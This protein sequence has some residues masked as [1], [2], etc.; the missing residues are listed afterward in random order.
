MDN[1]TA[2]NLTH[3]VRPAV[4]RGEAEGQEQT[5]GLLLLHG[6]GADEADLMGLA[7][8]LDPRLT[9]VS[10]RAPFRLGPGFAWYGMGQVGQPDDDTL[11]TSLDEL[12]EFI[13]GLPGAYNI[14][15]DRLYLL[16]FSQGAVVSSALAMLVPEAVRGVIMH[17]GYAHTY[18]ADL[19]LKPDGLEGKPFFMAHGLYDNVIPVQFGRD[20]KKFL[21][22]AH[23]RVTYREYPIAHSISQESLYDLSEWLTG[24][25]D[26]G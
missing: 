10:A 6:R 1:E 19:G 7:G 12:R 16:G 11:R 26:G 8:A 20:S 14:A 5:P 4:A 23:A 13:K 15:P 24:E 9:I 3:I 22:A 18:H 2:L 25:L 21:E 17:S